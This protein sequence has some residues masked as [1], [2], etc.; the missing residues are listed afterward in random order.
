MASFL[1]CHC[2]HDMEMIHTIYYYVDADFLDAVPIWLYC[3][4][5]GY[6]NCYLITIW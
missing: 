6:S 4:L 3:L 1:D 5:G 2:G